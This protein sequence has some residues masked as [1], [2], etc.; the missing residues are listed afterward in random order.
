M[1]RGSLATGCGVALSLIGVGDECLR[2]AFDSVMD[3]LD[4]NKT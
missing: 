4:S 2:K 3:Y 1:K